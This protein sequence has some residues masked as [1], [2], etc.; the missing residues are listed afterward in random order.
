MKNITLPLDT[1]GI[2]AGILC[3]IH[4]IGT[5]FFFI[6]KAAC[7]TCCSEAPLWWRAIDYLFLI[8]SFIAIYFLTQKTTKRWLILAF[9]ISWFALL[10]TIINESLQIISLFTEFIY[11]P[12]FS[13]II[14]HFYNLQFCKCENETCC[15][16]K[17]QSTILT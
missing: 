12:A 14:L 9:W 4:C 1:I 6:A 10:L 8:I 5:P 2:V 7:S 16:K 11:L 3:I 15:S 13:I 17:N